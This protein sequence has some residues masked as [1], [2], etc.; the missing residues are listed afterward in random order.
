[1]APSRT[2]T[3]M[4]RPVSCFD[5]YTELSSVEKEK[6]KQQVSYLLIWEEFHLL[7]LV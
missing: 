5:L 4:T 1:M 7:L 2:S 6:E 3:I